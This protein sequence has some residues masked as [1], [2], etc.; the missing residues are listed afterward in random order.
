MPNYNK[1]LL[2]GNL[3][4]DPELRYIP[5][6][7]AVTDFGMAVNRR[8]TTREGEKRD[9]TCFVEVTLFGK[10]AQTFCDY[11]SKGRPV[12]VEG[13]L[14][15]DSWTTK[16]GQRR[17]RLRVIG[18]RF[19]FLGGPGAAAPEAEEKAPAPEEEKPPEEGLDL[20]EEIPF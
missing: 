3:T 2:I 8:F 13:R 5:S 18:E 9:E 20:D 15:F 10:Q 6:G 19:Q 7:T 1:V 12:F 4:R 16:D 14:R 17:S 11:M